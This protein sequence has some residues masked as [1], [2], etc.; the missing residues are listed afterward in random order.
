MCNMQ[1]RQLVPQECRLHLDHQCLVL[2]PSCQPIFIAR[3]RLKAEQ[4]RNTMLK[5][6]LERKKRERDDLQSRMQQLSSQSTGT[7]SVTIAEAQKENA[8]LKQELAF[9][10]HEVMTVYCGIGLCCSIQHLNSHLHLASSLYSP[11]Q[12]TLSHWT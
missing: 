9:K 6:N 7:S 1:C 8:T 11:A 12:H 10:E 3:C 4:G 2:F 5:Q